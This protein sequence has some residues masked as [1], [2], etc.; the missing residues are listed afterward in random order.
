MKKVKK[1]LF[2]NNNR[3]NPKQQVNQA[4]EKQIADFQK[5]LS[6]MKALFPVQVNRLPGD[7]NYL[8]QNDLGA[9]NL[10]SLYD[11]ERE[12]KVMFADVQE[13]VEV[14]ILFGLGC[15]Y[16]LEYA[17]QHFADLERVIVVEPS[18]DILTRVLEHKEV[19]ARLARVKTITFMFNREAEDVGQ[20]M[21]GIWTR[22]IKKKHAMVYHLPYRTLFKDYF[23][24][25]Q[26][27]IVRNVQQTQVAISTVNKNIY[28]K[29]QN[30]INNINAPG[31]DMAE[32][33]AELQGKP[34]IMVSA[35]PSLDKN[36]HLLEAAKDKAFVVAVG[37]AVKILYNKG[38]RP[39][40]RAAFS[41][42]PDENTVF[43]GIAD[44]EN[45]PL[46]FANTL[47]YMVVAN[48][49]APKAR[50]VMI[51]DEISRY[52]YEL[53]GQSCLMVS[54]GGTIANVTLG[55][56]CRAGCSHI[57]FTGQ[58]L[59]MTDNR[60]YADGSWTDTRYASEQG[61]IK[62]KDIY[63]N[64]VIT[65]KPF[66]GIRTE[67][68]HMIAANNG[69]RFINATEGG[70]P[71]AGAPNMKLQEVLDE[72]PAG[73][74]ITASIQKLFAGAED[75]IPAIGQAVWQAKQETEQIL[76]LNQA[77]IEELREILSSEAKVTDI[78][79]A[80]KELQKYEDQMMQIPFYQ[81]VINTELSNHFYSIRTAHLYEGQD[82]DKQAESLMKTLI[83]YSQR[84][85]EY[86]QFVYELLEKKTGE[87]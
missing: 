44:F 10:H 7:L 23:E 47:D 72:L 36:I 83:G 58:D 19:V 26:Q 81:I 84:L 33:L 18:L 1:D 16:A 24:K 32:L 9:C 22:E 11:R 40:A 80:L 73:R 67:I 30:I 42:Y 27:V 53:S 38:I 50:M 75:Q 62:E 55:L 65:S 35:G 56:L 66:A 6:T 43:D 86:G 82:M 25:V 15:A 3:I 4:M 60:L 48:Y 52:C 87:L 8:I 12:M 49:N 78:V 85:A 70:L 59:C 46:L 34:A 13:D 74:G 77:R 63:G 57:I 69:I 51:G 61:F 2:K 41:P 37:S 17:G 28:L 54:G 14:L 76:A 79:F 71:L 31:I 68:E 29:T 21:A 39:H 64:D 20:E 5:G 45:I